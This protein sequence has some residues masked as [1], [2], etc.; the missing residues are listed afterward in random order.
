MLFPQLC[1]WKFALRDSLLLQNKEKKE[2]NF[3]KF[4]FIIEK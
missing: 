1:L 2:N 3:K 4:Y